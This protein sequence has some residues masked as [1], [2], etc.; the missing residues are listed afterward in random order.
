MTKKALTLTI[1]GWTGCT[2]AAFWAGTRFTGQGDGA[3]AKS[4]RHAAVAQA[5]IAAGERHAAK[6]AGQA[7]GAPEASPLS[8]GKAIRDLTAEETKTRM[9]DVLALDDPLARM[10]AFLDMVRGVQGDEQIAAAM[11]ALTEGNYNNRERGRE[12]G[13]LMTRWAKESPEKA[14]AWT[15]QFDDWRKQWG[16]GT[17]LS[18]WAEANP[19]AAIQWANNHPPEKKEDGN[20]HM[21]AAIAGIAKHNLDRASE[22]AQT[23]EQGNARGRAMDR[24]LDGFFKERGEEAAKSAVMALDEG[25]YKN[26]ILQRLAGRLADKDAKSAAAWAATLP[27][28]EARPRVV[29]EVID[30]WAENNPNDAGNWLNGMPRTAEMDG[31]RERFAMKVQEHD[32]EAAIAWASTITDER[33]RRNTSMRVVREWMNREPENAR[34][35]VSTSGLPDDMKT[36]LLRRRG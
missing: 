18:V 16:A 13:M 32:P 2:A 24:I 22:L 31:P 23:M 15:Q 19:D 12:F 29:T 30:E 26:G 8:R 9:K 1:L 27:P 35:W 14:L 11:D 33:M 17:A 28:G 4:G 36:R 3:A 20:Y 21:V 5:A 6:E 34:A 10:E 7:T 25:V